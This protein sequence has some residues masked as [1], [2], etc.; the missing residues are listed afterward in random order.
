[1]EQ[2]ELRQ[3]PLVALFAALAILFPQL[4]HFL[5]L[6]PAFL[7]IFIPVM[8]GSMF[9]TWRFV[10]L[11]A[12]LSPAI[13]WL[14]TGMPPIAPPILPVLILE[15]V[16]AGLI[17]S[18]LR[19]QTSLPVWGILLISIF[20]D[21]LVLFFLVLIIAPLLDITHPFFSI[22]LVAAGIPGIVLQLL[23][24]PLTVHLIE[25]KYPQWR[26]GERQD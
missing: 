12:I 8:V 17:I 15:L 6:G 4:F 20:V 10:I 5:G 1:M 18:I 11:L 7:P 19:M 2:H 26:P 13:S 24:V 3:I 23:T 25:K 22:A 14:I 21:R 16:V 9:L